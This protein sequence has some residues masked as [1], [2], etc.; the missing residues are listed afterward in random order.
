MLSGCVISRNVRV[1]LALPP[2]G[3][4]GRNARS[5]VDADAGRQRPP[6]GG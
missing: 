6:A 1:G 3:V 2:C 5:K 4:I